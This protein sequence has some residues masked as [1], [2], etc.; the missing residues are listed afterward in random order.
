MNP[1]PA[2][3]NVIMANLSGS[4]DLLRHIAESVEEIGT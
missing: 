4:I 2:F 3:L 1:N